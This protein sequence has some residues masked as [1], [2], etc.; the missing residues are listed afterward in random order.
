LIKVVGVT[1]D[2]SVPAGS[3]KKNGTPSSFMFL[4][5]LVVAWIAGGFS[6]NGIDAAI[7][8]A[9]SNT[10][11]SSSEVCVRD[12]AVEGVGEMVLGVGVL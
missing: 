9:T 11:S 12:D 2:A 3:P 1:A 7:N 10:G 8:K 6:G 5:V 4:R